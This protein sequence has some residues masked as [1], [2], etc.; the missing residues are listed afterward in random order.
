VST[1]NLEG[2]SFSVLCVH[3]RALHSCLLFAQGFRAVYLGVFFVFV[4]V[5]IGAAFSPNNG[6]LHDNIWD[7]LAPTP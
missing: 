2:Q 5:L 3:T 4:V 1:S 7:A 6:S